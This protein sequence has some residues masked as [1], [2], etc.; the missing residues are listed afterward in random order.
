[1][2]DIRPGIYKIGNLQIIMFTDEIIGVG[3]MGHHE[4]EDNEIQSAKKEVR[5][6]FPKAKTI[7]VGA[8]EVSYQDLLSNADFRQAVEIIVSE[9]IKAALEKVK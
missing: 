1:M 6:H 5:L 3:F 7:I 8:G 4:L 2:S 9:G